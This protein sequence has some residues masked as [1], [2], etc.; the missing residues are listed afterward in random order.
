MRFPLLIA[1]TVASF[2]SACG[3]DEDKV[4]EPTPPSAPETIRLTSPAFD[5]NETI[6]KQFSCEGAEASPPLRWSGVPSETRELALL[7]EDPD[8]LGG[9][10]V[11]WTLFHIGTGNKSLAASETPPG[12]REGKNDSGEVGYAGPCPPEGGEPH[13]YLFALYALDESLD[14]QPGAA[15]EEVRS[16][17]ARN[18]LARGQLIGKYGR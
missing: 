7:V 6:P 5:E 15:P 12:S 4:S 17:I 3:G 11:H 16:S 14:L 9:T 1:L 8:A 10:F 18:A 2:L 13:R